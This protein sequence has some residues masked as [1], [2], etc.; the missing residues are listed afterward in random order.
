MTEMTGPTL[1][2]TVLEGLRAALGDDGLVREIIEAFRADTPGQ[3]ATLVAAHERG[4]LATVV[5]AA[6]LVKGSAMTLGAVRLEQLCV[7]LEAARGE[8][9][10]QVLVVSEEFEELSGLLSDYLKGLDGT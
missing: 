9:G 1:D 5:A 3:I 7:T 8:S 2:V 6:H 4:D 10:D